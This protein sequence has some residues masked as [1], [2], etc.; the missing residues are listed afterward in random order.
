M[1]LPGQVCP[2]LRLYGTRSV[3]GTYTPASRKQARLRC[4]PSR[5][6]PRQS[7]LYA[8]V[9]IL[10]VSHSTSTRESA[11]LVEAE[12]RKP[13][14]RF[15][16]MSPRMQRPLETVT[17]HLSLSLSLSGRNEVFYHG[18]NGVLHSAQ[19]ELPVCFCLIAFAVLCIRLEQQRGLFTV[20]DDRSCHS[21][22]YLT[23]QPA[24]SRS[25]DAC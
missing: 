9:F 12:S 16:Y 11:S 17:R 23:G 20:A 7:N 13:K 19:R 14:G 10:A 15:R 18:F 22:C 6:P 5:R 21:T 25:A 4:R 8:A 24:G 3:Y 2:E 1:P